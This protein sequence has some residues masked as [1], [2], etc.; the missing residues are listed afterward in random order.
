MNSEK[1]NNVWKTLILAKPR[2]Y[3]L[4][5]LPSH[6]GDNFCFT[7]LSGGKTKLILECRGMNT[8]GFKHPSVLMVTLQL[9]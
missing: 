8:P 5:T 7:N 2:N 1:L 4:C 3:P 9:Q 6:F